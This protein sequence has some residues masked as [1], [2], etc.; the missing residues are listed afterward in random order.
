M[1]IRIE[2]ASRLKATGTAITLSGELAD[3]NSLDNP[4]NIAPVI[5]DVDGVNV[6]FAYSF[7]PYSLTV[8]RLSLDERRS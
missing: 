4:M 5:S 3:E 2:G 7:Q 6:E 1:T 8:L